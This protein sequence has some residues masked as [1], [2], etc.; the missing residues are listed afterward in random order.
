[1]AALDAQM[2]RATVSYLQRFIHI[3]CES[4]ALWRAPNVVSRVLMIPL[5][6]FSA[7]APPISSRCRLFSKS[8]AT[9]NRHRRRAA[10]GIRSGHGRLAT[11]MRFTR[12]VSFPRQFGDC[13]VR[14]IPVL[15]P[16]DVDRRHLFLWEFD[17]LVSI[18][19]L[20]LSTSSRRNE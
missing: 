16:C 1:M 20:R 10:L 3:S 19:D 12:L 13:G 11:S 9:L 6:L 15:P 5:I 17:T 8:D 18:G 4:M 2:G 7:S 14:S